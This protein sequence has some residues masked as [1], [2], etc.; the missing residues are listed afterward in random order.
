M[1]SPTGVSPA[2]PTLSRV[3]SYQ[4]YYHIPPCSHFARRYCGNLNWFLFLQVLRCFTSLR[5]LHRSGNMN[6][7]M[8]G[9]PIRK[10]PDQSFLAAPRGLS[11]PSTSFIASTSQGIHL[12]P[13]LTFLLHHL[14]KKM[15]YSN[16]RFSYCLIKLTFNKTMLKLFSCFWINNNNLKYIRLSLR[17]KQ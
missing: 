15:T 4:I 10:S 6:H 13:L 11:Q 7:S 5:S 2:V 9:C 1:I 8:L 17:L 12:W 14:S 3:F 16:L